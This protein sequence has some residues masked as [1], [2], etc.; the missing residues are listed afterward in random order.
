MQL[1]VLESVPAYFATAPDGR[2]VPFIIAILLY[3]EQ[4]KPRILPS[5]SKSI[6]RT[7]EITGREGLAMATI[8]DSDDLVIASKYIERAMRIDSAIVLFRCETP[9]T[10][11]RLMGHLNSNYALQMVQEKDPE[12]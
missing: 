6:D 1:P 12:E 2:T 7:I 5:V 8:M 4:R 3:D 11:E 9:E 10:C